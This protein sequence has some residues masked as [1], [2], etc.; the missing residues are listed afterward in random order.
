MT[1]SPPPGDDGPDL[2]R[3]AF[4]HDS[5]QVFGRVRAE[6]DVSIWMNVVIRAEMHEVVIGPC[7]N[8]QDFA[9]I[10]VGN[11]TPT[12]IGAHCSITHHTVLHGCRLGDRVL[13]GVGAVIMD[14]CEIGDDT[15]IGERALLTAGTRIPPR[16]IVMGAPGR[17]TRARDN[18]VGN[19]F[20]ALLYRW[21]ALAYRAGN[22]RSW[23]G[24]EYEAFVAET[25]R[26]LEA[27]AAAREVAISC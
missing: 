7:S 26:A 1:P 2:G 23:Q 4:V 27:E 15:I 18:Y 17:V 6:D 22:H 24:P 21:N 20:N 5:A 8:V 16:S 19:K 9:M 3:A 14:G 12:V 10:H 25:R 13:V 11:D